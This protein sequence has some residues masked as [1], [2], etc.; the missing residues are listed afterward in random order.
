MTFCQD[1]YN[2]LCKRHP[3]CNIYVIGD[4]HFYHQNI[5]KYTRST[6]SSVEEMNN[7]IRKCH[8]DIV[9]KNDIVI[10]LGDFCL[11][12][13]GIREFT[14]TLNGH[15]YLILGN[16]DSRSL[17]KRYLSVGFEGVY[18]TPV[19]I[20][21][22][23][24]SHEPL[25]KGSR[26]DL[27][28]QGILSEF[29]SSDSINYHGHI[30]LKDFSIS[31]AYVNASC[32]AL[33]YK[34]L[35][36]GR[37]SQSFIDDKPLFINSEHFSKALNVVSRKIGIESRLLLD[38]Y[39]YSF[40]LQ[41][42]S[43]YSSQSFIQGSFG[44]YKKYGYMSRFSDLDITV[45][46]NPTKSKNKNYEVLKKLS[47]ILYECMK[48]MDG[49]NLEFYKR[50][51]SLRMFEL[52]LARP[53]SLFFSGCS[54][55]NLDLLNSFRETDF[56]EMEGV[57]TLERYLLK[58]GSSS[59]LDEFYFP[60]FNVQSLKPVGDVSNLILQVLFQKDNSDRKVAALRKLHYLYKNVI[61]NHELDNLLDTFIRFFLRNIS[62]LSTWGRD[63]EV[64]YIK[65]CRN[66]LTSLM[67]SFIKTLP[68]SLLDQIY[69]VLINPNSL[70]ISVYDEI[71]SVPTK[72]MFKGCTRIM[73][74]FK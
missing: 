1:I 27:T 73:K 9:G 43:S 12:N 45:L 25:I 42:L 28:F 8:N 5:I 70:F 15:K 69:D 14:E 7:Y 74:Q 16:H 23:Y 11:N 62:L 51:H 72:D 2:M 65:N 57:S 20:N 32:E 38:D 63:D 6:F 44:L 68:Y 67:G 61:K 66:E 24:F 31:S 40:M 4:Q 17:E 21:D 22:S 30:H 3:G 41:G 64:E 58:S 59:L 35:L 46:Y 29:V 55:M 10:F 52:T 49:V 50:Y 60:K 54:D 34:P 19:K 13:S 53:D 33:M 26:S 47:D 56:M 39:V 18:V 48:A 37:T 36:V 71:I